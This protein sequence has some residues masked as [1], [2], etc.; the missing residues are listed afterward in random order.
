MINN[1][2]NLYF[3]NIHIVYNK[4]CVFDVIVSYFAFIYAYQQLNKKQI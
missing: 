2:I 4:L 3:K 1:N